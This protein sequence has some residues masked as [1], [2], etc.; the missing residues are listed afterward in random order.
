MSL[1]CKNTY[2]TTILFGA[3]ELGT[4][5]TK[6]WEKGEGYDEVGKAVEANIVGSC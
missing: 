5:Y 3:K 1:V 6:F 4:L 2:L